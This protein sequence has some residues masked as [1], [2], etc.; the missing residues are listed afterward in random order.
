MPCK[1]K[2]IVFLEGNTVFPLPIW[3]A[4]FSRKSGLAGCPTPYFLRALRLVII[5]NTDYRLKYARFVKWKR[6]MKMWIASVVVVLV[7]GISFVVHMP[8]RYSR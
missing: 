6:M 4:L 2:A 8:E 7:S 5:Y 3:R 1:C